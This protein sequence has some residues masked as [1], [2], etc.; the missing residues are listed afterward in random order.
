MRL[1]GE[2]A[3]LHGLIY[4]VKEFLLKSEENVELTRWCET[5]TIYMIKSVSLNYH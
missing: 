3:E 1:V 4:L 5:E 2:R